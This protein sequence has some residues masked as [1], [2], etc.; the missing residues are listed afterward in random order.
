MDV[1]RDVILDLLPLYLADEASADTKALVAA[2]LD[3]DPDLAALARNWREHL[4]A[5]PPAPVDPD[6][7]AKAFHQAQRLLL[8]RT[9]GL[10]ALIT[11]GALALIALLGAMYVFVR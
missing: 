1:T 10:A 8:I 9:L 3:R 6:A 11:F 4:S 5:P 2:H 7:Q